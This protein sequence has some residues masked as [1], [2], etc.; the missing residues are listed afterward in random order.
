MNNVHLK[1]QLVRKIFLDYAAHDLLW[2]LHL[3]RPSAGDEEDNAP[4]LAEV[5][6]DPG[7]VSLLRVADPA[8]TGGGE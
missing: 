2:G 4:D 7:T 8:R 5:R 3:E 1:T 6:Q